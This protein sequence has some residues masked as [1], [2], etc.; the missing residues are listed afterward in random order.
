[1]EPIRAPG[2]APPQPTGL[3]CPGTPGAPPGVL[4]PAPRVPS[5]WFPS[6]SLERRL[7]TRGKGP[8]IEKAA[9]KTGTTGPPHGHGAPTGPPSPPGGSSA[10]PGRGPR[11]GA[12]PPP[13]HGAPRPIRAA[14]PGVPAGSRGRGGRQAPLPGV[15][16]GPTLPPLRSRARPALTR[17]VHH[18]GLAALG[19]RPPCGETR[20]ITPRHRDPHRE[21]RGGQ[22][23]GVG[24]SGLAVAHRRRGRWSPHARPCRCRCRSH[25]QRPQP[26]GGG[27]ACA[28][29]RRSPP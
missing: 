16:A 13:P 5:G 10:P 11:G 9:G 8:S 26:D 15:R 17:V 19:E 27:A 28:Q 25:P 18:A 21:P 23:E 4:L 1:M 2:P 14:A 29:P 20:A 22:G 12:D 6:A 24:G 7:D 3:G